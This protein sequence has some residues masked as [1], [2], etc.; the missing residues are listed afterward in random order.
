[1]WPKWVCTSVPH[2]RLSLPE[3]WRGLRGD[4]LSQIA[5]IPDCIFVHANG[6][7][8]GNANREGTLAMAC[9]ALRLQLFADKEGN[10]DK[11]E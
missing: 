7:I 9:A 3:P 4:S 1:M 6:F 5:G 2:A 10:A 11:Q 8:G